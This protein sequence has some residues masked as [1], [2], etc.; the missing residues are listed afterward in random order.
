MNFRMPIP[1]VT[2]LGANHVRGYRYIKL[3]VYSVI[4]LSSG[5]EKM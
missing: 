2:I 5:L 3:S 4:S 1:A